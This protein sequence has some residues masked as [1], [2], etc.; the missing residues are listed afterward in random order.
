MLQFYLSTNFPQI[1]YHYTSITFKLQSYKN[2][3]SES[4]AH[5]VL[6]TQVFIHF[7]LYEQPKNWHL[8]GTLEKRQLLD[9]K[10]QQRRLNRSLGKFLYSSGRY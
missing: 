8:C 7:F 5:S 9:P 4:L 1:N 6:K 3:S 10:D 2:Q